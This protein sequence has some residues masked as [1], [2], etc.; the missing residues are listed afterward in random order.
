[1]APFP[2]SLPQRAAL[3]GAVLVLGVLNA[4][5][6]V[7]GAAVAA[8]AT[9]AGEP[10]AAVNALLVFDTNANAFP[11]LGKPG[12]TMSQ[13]IAEA[14]DYAGPG[15]RRVAALACTVL[16]WCGRLCGS[17]QDH[18][19]LALQGPPAGTEFWRWSRDDLAA[20]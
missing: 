12:M 10:R 19:T 14:R 13:R 5:F 2:L 8:A 9:L 6:Q 3:A 20:L 4:A 18:C 16:T 1:M 17:T 11:L 15:W 7:A